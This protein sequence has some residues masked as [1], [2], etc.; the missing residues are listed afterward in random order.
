MVT[1]ARTSPGW[2]MSFFAPSII[3]WVL[4]V[5]AIL[6]AWAG[7]KFAASGNVGMMDIVAAL[8]W[9]RDNIANFG[10]DPAN[11]TIMGQSGG[12]A[13]VCNLTAM[14]SAKGLFHKAVVLSGASRRAADKAYSEKLGAAVLK[15]SKLSL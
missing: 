7:K 6:P 10:G 15:E 9:V 2:V 3:A 8:E 12:G 5:S 4:W 13:K 1:T 11:V 14:P